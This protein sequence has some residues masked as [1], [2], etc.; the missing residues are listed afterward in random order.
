METSRHP[1]DY[2]YIKRSDG[3]ELHLI[4]ARVTHHI[5]GKVITGYVLTPEGQETAKRVVVDYSTVKTHRCLDLDD[6]GN[7]VINDTRMPRSLR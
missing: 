5:N 7:L 1:T 3:T 6:G 4:N 2:E